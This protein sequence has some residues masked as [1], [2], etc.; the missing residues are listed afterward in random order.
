MHK[1]SK[2]WTLKH[3]KEDSKTWLNL[4]KKAKKEYQSDKRLIE[5]LKK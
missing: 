4:S 3:L 1:T 5:K 2:Y